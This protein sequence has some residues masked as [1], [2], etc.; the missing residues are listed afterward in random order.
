MFPKTPF[1]RFTNRTAA[2][3][4]IRISCQCIFLSKCYINALL[5]HLKKHKILF[6]NPFSKSFCCQNKEKVEYWHF[7]FDSLTDRKKKAPYFPHVCLNSVHKR[8]CLW[9]HFICVVVVYPSY[10]KLSLT[11]PLE[12]SKYPPLKTSMTTKTWHNVGLTCRLH[13]QIRHKLF[14]SF[15]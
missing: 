4:Y 10:Q 15:D 8:D 6:W 13:R 12:V 3:K 1:L 5:G 7:Q 14:K 2:K 9:D 11:T